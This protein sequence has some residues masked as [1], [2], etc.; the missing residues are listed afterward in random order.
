MTDL[1]SNPDCDNTSLVQRL[2]DDLDN[3]VSD[4]ISTYEEICIISVDW[5]TVAPE[6]AS[7]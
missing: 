6:C 7:L 1:L 2:Q 4:A 3:A 5:P